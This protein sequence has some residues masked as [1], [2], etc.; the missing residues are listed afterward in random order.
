[1]ADVIQAVDLMRNKLRE[2]KQADALVEL[3]TH[4]E[5]VAYKYG[6]LYLLAADEGNREQARYYN[7]IYRRLLRRLNYGA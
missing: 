1:M 5:R 7:R 4:D 6:T 2:G 3:N